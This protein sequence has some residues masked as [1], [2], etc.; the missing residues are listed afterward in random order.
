MSLLHKAV[1]VT[2]KIEGMSGAAEALQKF[3]DADN[4]LDQTAAASQFI[5][6]LAVAGATTAYLRTLFPL[7]RLG[8]AISGTMYKWE[9]LC[10][11][12]GYGSGTIVGRTI[13]WINDKNI[14]G[15]V[16]DITHVS[17]FTNQ[18]FSRAR[19]NAYPRDPLALDL[20]GAAFVN[21]VVA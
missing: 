4:T 8:F 18:G 11:V 20:D 12:A 10:Y 16:Y 1:E 14:G 7:L 3:I 2:E 6:E 17:P 9:A 19:N 15:W 13:D 21:V 5:A